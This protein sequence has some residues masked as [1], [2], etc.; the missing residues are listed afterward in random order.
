M[1]HREDPTICYVWMTGTVEGRGAP[2]WGC[3]WALLSEG[4][5]GPHLPTREP[6]LGVGMV[7]FMRHFQILSTEPF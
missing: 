6:G 3:L 5:A 1:K 2:T 7:T 4:E